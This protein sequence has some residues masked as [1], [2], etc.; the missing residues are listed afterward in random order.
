VEIGFTQA[1]QFMS[2]SQYAISNNLL[3]FT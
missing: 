2:G 1:E 3:D